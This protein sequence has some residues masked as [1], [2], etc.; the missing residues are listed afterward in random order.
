MNFIYFNFNVLDFLTHPSVEIFFY[1]LI[2]W[3][4]AYVVGYFN[5]DLFFTKK[6]GFD[7]LAVCK[8]AKTPFY[9][10][11]YAKLKP[12][13][14]LSATDIACPSLACPQMLSYQEA[15]NDQI[16]DILKKH[17]AL[18]QTNID[19]CRIILAHQDYPSSINKQ[20]SLID[21]FSGEQINIKEK[22]T[23]CLE[24]LLSA[25]KT[26]FHVLTSN[27]NLNSNPQEYGLFQST[28]QEKFSKL[29]PLASNLLRSLSYEK[30]FELAQLP[31]S[32]V[33]T[34][35]LA[36]EAGKSLY[37]KKEDEVFH[38]IS[39]YPQLQARA[40]LQSLQNYFEDYKGE[41]R[42]IIRQAILFA[43]R[44]ENNLL[45]PEQMPVSSQALRD[46]L[47]ILYSDLELQ[48]ETSKR[49]ELENLLSALLSNLN[50][51]YSSAAKNNDNKNFKLGFIYKTLLLIPIET[52]INF[53]FKDIESEK[54]KRI[55][56]L[57]NLS[58]EQ[59]T[60]AN[61]ILPSD[62]DPAIQQ[63]WSILKKVLEKNNLL[64][65]KIIEHNIP[66]NK[67]AFSIHFF[68]NKNDIDLIGLE[69]L[70]ALR[71]K[72]MEKIIGLEALEDL[73]KN[74]EFE[75]NIRIY[76]DKSTYLKA[77]EHEKD[78]LKTA[79]SPSVQSTIKYRR[80]L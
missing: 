70:V 37:Y 69:N 68:P 65:T 66:T 33:A 25:H 47:E 80:A 15:I 79:F 24:S 57:L 77:L 48:Q 27:K 42:L 19:L 14:G 41:T 2:I 34:A 11:F 12:N 74:K 72:K 44:E 18:N 22:T 23:I 45:L 64:S 13:N 17:S 73:I 61:L 29:N 20:E 59:N 75:Q 3:V 39:Q 1:V 46:L 54:I 51:N 58:N 7:L 50:K 9:S 55:S 63:K 4:L 40:T 16:A 49:I 6:E 32:L 5:W 56:D 53:A 78:L 52:L 10:G 60:T 36:I 31:A 71:L 43:L 26:L 30:A 76:L 21:T 38:R 35:Y 8:K 67:L 62:I 28:L